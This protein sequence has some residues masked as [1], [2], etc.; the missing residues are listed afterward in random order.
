[1]P[2]SDSRIEAWAYLSRVIE[3]PSRHLQALIDQG[4]DIEEIACGVKKRAPWIGSLAAATAARYHI[5]RAKEDLDKAHDCGARLITPEDKEWP[6]ELFDSGFGFAE[7]GMSQSPKGQQPDAARPHALWVKGA[8]IRA[9]TAQSLTVVGTRAVS[10]YGRDVTELM[11]AGLVKHQWTIISGGAL[12]V[13]TIAHATALNAGGATVV[14]QACGINRSYPAAN[15]ALFRSI[16]KSPGG[17]LISEYPPDA[18]PYR[19]RFLTRNRLAAVLGQGTVV[20]QAAWRSGA[21]NTLQWAASLGRQPMAVPGPIT[22]INS[23]GC[24]EKIKT[25]EAQM[26]RSPNEVRELVQPLGTIDPEAQYELDFAPTAVQRLS[27]NEL[28][29]YDSTHAQPLS[30]TDIAERAGLPVGLTM[31]LLIELHGKNMV[32]RKRNYWIRGES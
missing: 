4:H 11:V 14:V 1:M 31:H 8:N 13:D 28:R 21:L 10:A 15:R 9:L 18:P 3:G 12:G 32:S 7:R 22:D 26:V 5:D 17:A 23:F 19:H 25:G 30:A 29:V 27:R 2:I 16:A 20:T 24:L 6:G